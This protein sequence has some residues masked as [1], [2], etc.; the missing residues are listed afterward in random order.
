[1]KIRSVTFR[2]SVGVNPKSG[3]TSLEGTVDLHPA[4]VLLTWMRD[5]RRMLIPFSNIRSMDVADDE[6]EAKKP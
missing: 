5:G 1:M 2:D 6:K 4:G 3:F